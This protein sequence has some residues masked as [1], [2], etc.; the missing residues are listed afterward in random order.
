MATNS[1]RGHAICTRAGAIATGPSGPA[2]CPMSGTPIGSWQRCLVVATWRSACA[3]LCDATPL[4]SRCARGPAFLHAFV[5]VLLE[6]D[7]GYRVREEGES[8]KTADRPELQRL[9]KVLPGA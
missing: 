3:G 8:A 5:R 6:G 7:D 4:P 1:F 2:S 9:L